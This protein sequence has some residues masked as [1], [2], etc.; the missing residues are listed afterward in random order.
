MRN[1]QFVRV[2]FLLLGI[3]C[4]AGSA[5]SDVKVGERA[6]PGT[7][8]SML[9]IPDSEIQGLKIAALKGS[10]EAARRLSYHYFFGVY[11][12]DQAEYWT[13]IGAEDGDPA[14]EFSYGT[15]LRDKA[16]P[17]AKMRAEYWRAKAEKDGF[18]LSES[19]DSP[20]RST[21]PRSQ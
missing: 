7:M 14:M 1:R 18:T 2:V 9:I 15:F 4:L 20:A 21:R 6:P 3:S 12:P 8:N 5:F 11:Y 17:M 10:G 13:Q 16:D 19:K